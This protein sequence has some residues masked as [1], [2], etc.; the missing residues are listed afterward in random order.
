M[1]KII[2]EDL[3]DLYPRGP[4]PPI[5]ES[6]G[7]LFRSAGVAASARLDPSPIFKQQ[8]DHHYIISSQKSVFVAPLKNDYCAPKRM[9]KNTNFIVLL[10]ILRERSLSPKE[11]VL[12][13]AG[14][15]IT[16]GYNHWS[17]PG[18]KRGY[19]QIFFGSQKTGKN[20]RISWLLSDKHKGD[21]FA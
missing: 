17:Y 5:G 19:N 13:R 15:V 14:L 20:M 2:L 1:A 7:I 12:S 21:F 16:I 6:Q 10:I 3:E 18:H 4:I 9:G 8:P 11:A